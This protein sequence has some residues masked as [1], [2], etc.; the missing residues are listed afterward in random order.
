MRHESQA[1]RWQNST[2][3]NPQSK[4]TRASSR[5]PSQQPAAATQ[6]AMWAGLP[7]PAAD[8]VSV[9]PARKGDTTFAAEQLALRRS[10]EVGCDMW[11]PPRR[12]RAATTRAPRPRHEHVPVLRRRPRAREPPRRLA[13]VRG[14]RERRRAGLMTPNCAPAIECHYAI[15]GWAGCVALNLNPRL[16][17]DELA[18]CLEGADCEVLVADTSYA[19]LVR[20]ALQRYSKI[21]AVVWTDV[22]QKSAADLDVPT[23]LYETIVADGPGVVLSR[24]TVLLHA[25]G[26]MVEH[27]I[28]R[29]DVWLHCAPMFHLV[30][31][32]A[33]FAV[34]WVAGTHVT[35]P[36][37]AAAPVF[38]ALRDHRVTVSNVASTMVTLLLADPAVGKADASSLE[39]LS[40]GGRCSAAT[41]LSA[42][43]TF[44]C[45]FFL[46]YGMT[47]CCGKISMSLVDEAT[48]DRVGPAKTLD[49][50]TTSGRLRLLE[51]RVGARDG[52]NVPT[53]EKPLEA[54]ADAVDV[55]PGSG[56]VGEVWIRG[57][58]LFSGYN[59]NA[60][61]T[62]EAITPRL[63]PHGRPR[64]GRVL[65]AAALRRHAAA[66]LAD[67][68]VPS[69]IEF[70]ARA[71]LPMT[72]SGKV[73]KAALKKRDAKLAEERKAA[74][75]SRK[76]AA[77]PPS[78][79]A[80]HVYGVTWE[81]AAKMTG[82]T[83]AILPPAPAGVTLEQEKARVACAL[84]ESGEDVAGVVCLTALGAGAALGDDVAGATKAALK[85]PS[86]SSR[87][88]TS[89]RV[90]RVRRRGA[91]RARRGLKA[92]PATKLRVWHLAGVVDDGAAPALT[93]DR[94]A[95][96]LKPKVDGSLHLHA[97]SLKTP[98]DT[99]VLFSSIYGLL[100][101]R[102]L[103]HYG[104]A[105]AFQDGL[106]AARAGLPA[107]AV[108]WGTWAD[109]GMAHRFGS[110]FEAHVNTRSAAAPRARTRSPDASRPRPP[111]RAAAAPAAGLLGE[112][113]AAAPADRAAMLASRVAAHVAEMMGVDAASLDRDEP[114]TAIG[115]SS[116][117][118]VEMVN[119]LNE[120]LDE[121]FSPTMVFEHLAAAPAAA[122]A[123]LLASRVA[124]HVAEMMGVDAA[125]LDSD[126]PV[127]AIGL[128]SMH[129]VEMVNFLNEELDEDFSPTMV[130]EH[131]SIG[132]V[133]AHV[134]SELV[135]AAAPASR[136]ARR[137]RGR[138]L[139][140]GA[141]SSSLALRLPGDANSPEALWANLI[142]EKDAVLDDVPSDRPHNGRPSAYL[143]ALTVRGFDRVAFGISAAEATAMDPQQRLVLECCAEALELGERRATPAPPGGD[144]E[145]VGVFA[146]IETSDAYLHQR[147]VDEGA[148]STDA[149][150]GTGWHGCVG[151][152]RVSYLFDL[153]ARPWR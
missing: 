113:A 151:P 1:A 150:C 27:R 96:V 16:S 79:I 62:A 15:A 97:A 19:G 11:A 111:R 115:L 31:A 77:Q 100:G 89:R 95:D 4:K 17:P 32:Y 38:D 25:L 107:L 66:K 153:R 91:P 63:V 110:G 105:N 52:S 133:C 121:D 122:R 48:R 104:A 141:C 65:T 54:D 42:L 116:M 86:R 24:E 8:A 47:E 114:V 92:T 57:P 127:T 2:P 45:E 145:D 55:A 118:T 94:F 90:A 69:S 78:G 22:L 142:A 136:A 58:T 99:F 98:V 139:R 51:V 87:P 143:S 129:T 56:G 108:S 152:N 147:A 18:Y 84:E 131:V 130:F 59:N 85:T 119:F 102:E 29:D 88:S 40:C 50:I 30:D 75:A 125:S 21:R 123:G 80:D 61:A 149:Y 83:A 49:L 101:S 10:G 137:A 9:P 124:A 72:G 60:K 103:T 36:A 5:T 93:W 7:V 46:S 41:V 134:V 44:D 20:E 28:K 6:A 37:F 12:G 73:A 126:E 26:C 106:A 117:H 120:E 132:G 39:M 43:A 74:R 67:F 140:P 144:G 148:A 146:A 35:V 3:A 64:Q 70:M 33:I 23:F 138:C 34:T 68:K 13:P 109:A 128:S 135:S 81:L 76:Q 53:M 71:D 112:L 14:R 82:A